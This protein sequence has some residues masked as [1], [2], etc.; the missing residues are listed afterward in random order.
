MAQQSSLGGIGGA[1][2]ALTGVD[3]SLYGATRLGKK[4]LKKQAQL[5]IKDVSAPNPN[6]SPM[7]KGVAMH[8]AL[9]KRGI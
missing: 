7:E 3:S 9:S 5:N 8:R 4:K 2:K 6:I 1:L